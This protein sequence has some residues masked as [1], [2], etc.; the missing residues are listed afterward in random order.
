MKQHYSN[1]MNQKRDFVTI[2]VQA[3][4]DQAGYHRRQQKRPYF[5][6]KTDCI[7]LQ[8]DHRTLQKTQFQDGL[9]DSI[10]ETQHLP[11]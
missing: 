9:E 10:Q 4:H 8:H 3:G 11:C 6:P 5:S 7:C 1:N 2:P